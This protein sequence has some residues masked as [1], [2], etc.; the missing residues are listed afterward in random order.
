MNEPP[1]LVSR[2]CEVQLG[3]PNDHWTLSPDETNGMLSALD[4]HQTKKK[5]F[6]FTDEIGNHLGGSFSFFWEK[7]SLRS[8]NSS[9]VFV[10]SIWTRNIS[11][12]DDDDGDDGDDD[13]DGDDGDDDDNDDD[14]DDDAESSPLPPIQALSWSLAMSN[15]SIEC[16]VII[17]F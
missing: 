9:M 10:E 4:E 1:A 16:P 13:D 17:I 11:Y 7:M 8:A 3:R 14:D 12:N 6:R 5:E 15:D 2:S